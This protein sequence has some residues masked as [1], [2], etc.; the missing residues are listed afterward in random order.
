MLDLHW[1]KISLIAVFAILSFTT[2]AQIK[3]TYNYLDFASK[4]YYFG[5]TLA[6]NTSSFQP[7]QSSQ[8]FSSDSIRGIEG[9]YGQGFNLG[10]VTNLKIGQYF[11]FRFLPTLSFADRTL[12]YTTASNSVIDKRIEAVFFEMPFHVRYKSEPYKDL[13]VFVVGGVKYSFDVA[14]QSRARQDSNLIKISPTDFAVEIGA[15]VQFFFPYFIFSPELKFSQGMSNGLIH[16]PNLEYS[17]VLDKV[18][19]RTF[20]LSFHFEG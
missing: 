11:D 3:G 18:L 7:Y 17:T 2:N 20:T 5:I 14:S 15:G 8:F 12:Q 9:L 13:R 16:N 4:P 6:Y 1:K 10:I 19:S